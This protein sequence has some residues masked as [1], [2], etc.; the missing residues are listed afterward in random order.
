[1]SRHTQH[2]L[3][4]SLA[5]VQAALLADS[6][7][8]NIIPVYTSLPSDLLTPV[9]AYLKLSN[10]ADT[11]RRSFLFESVT[12]GEKIGRYSFLGSDPLKIIRTGP[13]LDVEGDP[14]LA[15][16]KELSPYKYIPVQGLPTF[17]GGAIG[18]ISYD[19]VQYF[20]PRTKRDLKDVLGI[21]ESVFMVADSLI[22]F[23]TSSRPFDASATFT[24]PPTPLARPHQL[25]WRHSTT[26][27]LTRSTRSSRPLPPPPP[28]SPS[29][30]RS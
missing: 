2:A 28:P 30:P 27:Q 11:S 5:E 19:C 15:I 10:G 7:A 20:E 13:G 21:P 29:S 23:D 1:M 14:L 25:M 26:R 8:G 24:C 3:K 9:T 16:E 22:V 18:Y 17:T 12:G 6:P 4:P